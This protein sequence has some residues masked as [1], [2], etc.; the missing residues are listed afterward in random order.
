MAR[1]FPYPPPEGY[2][3]IGG[4]GGGRTLLGGPIKPHAETEKHVKKDTE[5]WLKRKSNGSHKVEETKSKRIKFTTKGGGS[6]SQK[7]DSKEEGAES[8]GVTEEHGLPV[9]SQS[10][11]HSSESVRV[12]NERPT[13]AENTLER[14]RN[15][16]KI[17][18]NAPKPEEPVSTEQIGQPSTSSSQQKNNDVSER[19][20]HPPSTSDLRKNEKDVSAEVG[21]TP[22]HV[23]S[24]SKK[25]SGSKKTSKQDLYESLTSGW[26]PPAL[27]SGQSEPGVELDWLFASRKPGSLSTSEGSK[28]VSS[29]SAASSCTAVW[30]R[31][32]F[33]PEV[34]VYS[35]PYTVPF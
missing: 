23:S 18:L 7:K 33:L 12:L 26:M 15:V 30:P 20:P 27:Q 10:P 9:F 29:C 28:I 35:L 16:I 1:C 34:E 31:A 5:K 6:T 32:Q 11:C 2:L 4:G 24:G 21:K 19:L 3:G 8:S 13:A 14:K 25:R 17:K 22:I